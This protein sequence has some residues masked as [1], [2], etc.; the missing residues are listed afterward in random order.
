MVEEC[1]PL[2]ARVIV[3]RIWRWHFGK[4][5]VATPDNFGGWALGHSPETFGLV[6]LQVLENNWSIKSSSTDYNSQLGKLP[7]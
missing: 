4:G 2:V 7:R 1:K 3:N 6:G 5:L